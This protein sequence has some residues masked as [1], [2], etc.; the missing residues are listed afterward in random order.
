M[1]INLSEKR[2]RDASAEM[3]GDENREGEGTVPLIVFLFLF[4]L[5]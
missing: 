4:Y 5:I 1:Y 2:K 3:V